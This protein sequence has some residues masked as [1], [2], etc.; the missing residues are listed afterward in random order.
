MQEI[1]KKATFVKAINSNKPKY[2]FGAT[3]LQYIFKKINHNLNF[4]NLEITV[5]AVVIIMME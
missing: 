4:M 3:E 5:V 1:K 2:I